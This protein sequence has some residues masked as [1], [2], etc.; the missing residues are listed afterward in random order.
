MEQESTPS[1]TRARGNKHFVCR[2]PLEIRGLYTSLYKL[3]YTA[4][5]NDV[6]EHELLYKGFPTKHEAIEYMQDNNIEETKRPRRSKPSIYHKKGAYWKLRI[7]TIA[8]VEL[9]ARA[10]K[11]TTTDAV[12][13]A[14]QQWCKRKSCSTTDTEEEVVTSRKDG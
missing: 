9:L 4:A 7:D 5:K 8:Q 12:E 14:L 13:E 3:R 1:P 11:M 6:S 10:N 2:S